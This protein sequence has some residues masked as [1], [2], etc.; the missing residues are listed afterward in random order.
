MTKPAT[1]DQA[2]DAVEELAPEQQADLIELVRRR[3]A[4]RERERVIAQVRESQ[5][6]HARG[7][8]KVVSVHELMR[9]ITQ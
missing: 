4:E 2:L 8:S 7:D 9:E 5:S 1:F 6:E 3:L